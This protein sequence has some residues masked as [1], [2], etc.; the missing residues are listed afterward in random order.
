[1]K[2]I[3]A[4]LL[5]ILVVG[6]FWLNDLVERRNEAIKHVT[7]LINIGNEQ[8]PNQIS[9]YLLLNQA[10]RNKLD[11]IYEYFILEDGIELDYA[12]HE[13][14]QKNKF[15]EVFCHTPKLKQIV[16][17]EGVRMIHDFKGVDGE[18]VNTYIF[19]IEDCD[20]GI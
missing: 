8:F 14:I 10:Y 4:V 15:I 16:L 18:T 12:E 2:Y 9:D 6:I 7:A 3:Y 20:N 5:F 17:E 1:M 13:T 11:V 19:S